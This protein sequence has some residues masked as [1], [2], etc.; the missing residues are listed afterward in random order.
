MGKLLTS[1]KSTA[2]PVTVKTKVEKAEKKKHRFHPGTR[3]RF[4]MR[5]LQTGKDRTMRLLQDAT[6]SR[7][8]RSD[9]V[10]GARDFSFGAAALRVIGAGTES[11][12][13]RFL[14]CCALVMQVKGRTYLTPDVITATKRILDMHN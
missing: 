7:I 6:V 3:A 5:A 2:A 1:T 12:A 9:E 10:G 8:A 14:S 4:Q 11:Y 13:Q